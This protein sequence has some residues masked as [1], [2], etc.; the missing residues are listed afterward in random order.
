MECVSYV[1]V[2]A[3]CV[4]TRMGENVLSETFSFIHPRVSHFRTSGIRRRVWQVE[5]LL[6]VQVIDTEF[7]ISHTLIDESYFITIRSI[8]TFCNGVL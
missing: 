5:N 6:Q 2:T 4:S 3:N 7:E 8:R 1:A